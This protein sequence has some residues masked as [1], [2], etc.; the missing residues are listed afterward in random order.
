[1][2]ILLIQI[3][4]D[5]PN[6]ALMKLSAY[7]KKQ[8]N[9][10]HLRSCEDPDIVYISCIYTWNR[11]KA[12]SAST[13]YPDATIHFGGSGFEITSKLSDE[14][15][16]LKPDYDLY[17]NFDCSMGFLSRGCIRKCPWCIVQ[18][19]EG[20][21]KEHSPLE[22][23]LEPRFD[24]IILLD[25][26][27]LALP[28]SIEKLKEL[29]KIN[30]KICFNQG[31]DIRLINQENAE[32]LSQLKYYDLKFKDRRLYFAWDT[33]EIEPAVLKGIK[34]LLNAG[35]RADHLMFYVLV[36]FNTSYEQDIYRVKTLIDLGVKPYVM[37]YNGIKGTYQHHLKRWIEWRYYKVVSWEEYDHG[38]SQIQ[39][40]RIKNGKS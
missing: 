39:I 35:I 8:D 33:P 26:N 11:E 18:E 4:G 25:G 10:V 28:T 19:K 5:L 21:I 31:L 16:H 13:F 1:M 23:F 40:K 27:F 14:I 30:K 6:L 17:P 9:E 12:L 34:T 24:K 37:L 38:D 2:K 15:E 20:W 7:H 3:D 29:Q 32:L 36:C 22:E